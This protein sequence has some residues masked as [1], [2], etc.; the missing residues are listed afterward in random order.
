MALLAVG[1]AP[2]QVAT[3][4]LVA[5]AIGAYTVVDSHAARQYHGVSYVFAVFATVGVTTT[6]V[7]M[8]TG[9][10]RALRR[11][12]ADAWRRTALAGTISVITYGLV[13]L[14]VR[15]APVGYVAALR[16]S[17]VLIAT[18]IGWRVLGERRGLLRTTAAVVIVG[19]LL[20]LV[21]AR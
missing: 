19:G 21:T 5:V 9:R 11:V 8:A 17:S 14:A 18:V 10:F 1:A 7:G 16:E 20:V 6:C 12:G 4:S 3:A 2:N 13:L 15:R